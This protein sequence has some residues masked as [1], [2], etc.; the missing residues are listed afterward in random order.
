MTGES[1]PEIGQEKGNVW[2]APK[3]ELKLGKC[4]GRYKRE[5]KVGNVLDGLIEFVLG[6]KVF[7]I[8][9]RGLPDLQSIVIVHC[10]CHRH[11]C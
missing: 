1:R 8:A 7:V 2:Y 9:F 3:N 4:V 11:V 6:K 5:V 10:Q